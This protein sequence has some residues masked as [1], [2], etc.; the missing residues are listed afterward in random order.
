MATIVTRAGKGSPLTHNEVDANFNNLNNDKVEES[1][2]ITAGTG[3]TGGGDLSANRTISLANTAVAAGS[4]GSASAV[5]T[6]TVDAQGRLT[7]ASNTN[8]AIANTAVS[9]LGTM[10]TQNAN[11]VAITG[12]SINGTTVGASTASTGAFTTLSASSG[13]TIF[14]GNLAFT[15]TAQRITGDMSNA[16]IASR[17][18]FQT[19]TA[20]TGT[21][22]MAVPNG[23]GSTSQLLVRGKAGAADDSFGQVV[24]ID[25]TEFR[26]ASGAAGTG[27][28]SPMTFYTGGSERV[29]IDTSGNVGIGT[30]SPD[31]KLDIATGGSSDVVAALGGTFPAFTY[32]NGSG[33][34]FH[35][36]KHPSSDYFYIGNGATPTTNINLVV[37]SSGNVGIGTASTGFNA[38]GLPLVVGSGS[39]NTGM[40]IYSGT[41]S[42]GSIH[43]AD[44]VTTG[45]DGYRGFLNYTH[46]TNSMQFGTDATERMRIDSVGRI[47]LGGIPDNTDKFSIKGALPSASNFSIGIGMRVEVPSTTTTA[48]QMFT[49]LL[50]TQAASFTLT[51][52]RHFHAQQVSIGA[53]SAI[54]N[55]YGYF[56]DSSLTGATNN[57]GFYG[58]IASGSNRWNFYAAGT[59]RNYFTGR[60]DVGGTRIEAAPAWNGARI[61]SNT[62]IVLDAGATVTI[63]ANVCGGAILSVYIEGSGNGGLFWA[64]YSQVVAKI[65]GNGEATDTGSDFAVYKNAASH[66]VT[67]KNKGAVSQTF[68][69]SVFGANVS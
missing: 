62:S 68:T 40:T 54:T 61:T 21:T 12:G 49:S 4:Y 50:Y 46:N 33:A 42:G 47:G 6:F 32:R 58:N 28:Q 9:G 56:A 37:D 67:L 1:T 41:A 24:I 23:T 29:R 59:A 27:T 2:T 53:G 43:F 3:L 16:T 5:G 11:S 8:I 60:T 13:A 66:T 38:A 25:G 36:G 22:I 64:N 31:G 39:G 44:T 30:A 15:T 63:A 18:A 19:S 26:I 48:A 52:F 51:D 69:V 35:A 55:Q 17:L 20:N 10:S 65:T 7:A 57:Y 45:A 34:W 14:G